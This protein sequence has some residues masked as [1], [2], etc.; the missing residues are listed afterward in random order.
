MIIIKCVPENAVCV[1]VSIDIEE[2]CADLHRCA[3]ISRL[4]TDHTHTRARRVRMR[5]I[6]HATYRSISVK[7]HACL[8]SLLGSRWYLCC[9]Y[10]DTIVHT[11]RKYVVNYPKLCIE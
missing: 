10:N 2:F 9:F 5:G 4:L 11:Y 1:V 7:A 8:P 6:L 3:A